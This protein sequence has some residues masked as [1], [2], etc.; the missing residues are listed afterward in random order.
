[1]TPKERIRNFCIIA[2]IDHGKST[3]ADRMLERTGAISERE[4]MDQVLDSMDL[5][6]ERGITIKASAVRMQWQAADGETYLLNLID[7][8]GHVDFQYEVS[9][10]LRACEGAVLLVDVSQGVEA[11]TVSNAYLALEEGLEI[12]PVVNKIDLPLFDRDH[13]CEEI[14][15]TFGLDS[16]EIVFTSGKTGEGVAELL[17]A[18]V[19]RVPPPAGKDDD[20]LRA[21]IFDSEFDQH[22]GVV[23]YIRVEDGLVKP[24]DRIRM[25]AGGKEFDVT[26]V[27]V[28]SPAM[29]RTDCLPAG[30]VGYLMANVKGVKD[31]RV[32]DTITHAKNPATEPFPGYRPAKPMVF[33]GLYPT[34][35]ADYRNL[36]D[37]LDKLSLNDASL[38]YEPETSAALG[39][40]FRCGFLGL[41]HMEIVQERLEREYDLDLVATAPSV[42]YRIM[43]KRGEVFE[44][45]NPAQIPEA[46]EIE[47]FEEPVVNATI[48]SPQK[49]VGACMQLSEDRRGVFERM[50]Y[51]YGDRVA[52][53]YRLPLG[54]IIVD[55][56]DALKSSTRGY[57]TLDYE[58]AGYQESDLVKVE[59]SINGDPVDALA[60]ITHRQFADRRGRSICSKL[61]ETIPRQLFEVRI[62]ASIGGRVISSTRVQPLRKD[63]LEKCYG[64]DITRKRKL[65]EKQ[66]EGKKRMKQVGHVEVPQE[67]FMAVLQLD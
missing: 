40:G 58:L 46:G 9:R 2:H 66:K 24:G 19:D 31:A 42:V 14:E 45:E 56:Y 44:V 59:I 37:A 5:E 48:M 64:G 21:L 47:V 43:N 6:R 60:V 18:I 61:K 17:Q 57:A 32:G 28:F 12:I 23:A 7:T 20:P 67:A 52:L 10:A 41:L 26:E 25:M 55:Y 62:Q 30:H 15:Q 8:P 49:H 29:T 54:E 27:G 53:H 65:L 35:N 13:A 33:C 38:K 51:L 4:M 63:V 16:E 3:L 39:F 34:D 50:D 36:Q 11:Q 22:R 1:M